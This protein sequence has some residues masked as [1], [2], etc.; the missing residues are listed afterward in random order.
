VGFYESISAWYDLIFP[1][2]ADTV[3]FLARRA[4]PQARVLDIACGTGGHALALAARG[5][6]RVTGI[7]LDPA[8]IAAARGKAAAGPFP[9]RFEVLDM[10]RVRE[11]FEPGFG[12]VYCV[13][14]SLVHLE[15]E[16]KI[17]ALLR[18]CH[19]LLA[20]GGTLVVQII[21]YDRIL[22]AGLTELPTLRSGGLEVRRSY[23][24]RA[25]D[26]VVQF[27]TQLRVP[28]EEGRPERRS[29]NCLPLWILTR[30]E[31]ERLSREAGFRD[32]R[33]FGGF[34]GRPLAPESLPLVLSAARG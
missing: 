14:N 26:P 31:L 17:G 30:A 12:L 24:Y 19:A 3:E 13:G 1:V 32:L 28:A 18:D 25:G 10:Q 21:H 9:P 22:A 11:C 20:P 27:C 6:R 5:L 7:D 2:E 34:D 29:D 33:L 4:A 15:S 23:R 16:A 8:M